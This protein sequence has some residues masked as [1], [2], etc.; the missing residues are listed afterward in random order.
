[1]WQ[2]QD[3]STRLCVQGKGQQS[4]ALHLVLSLRKTSPGNII[5]GDSILCSNSKTST[6]VPARRCKPARTRKKKGWGDV[7]VWEGDKS[8]SCFNPRWF[9]FKKKNNNQFLFSFSCLFS[10]ERVIFSLP[11]FLL[12]R[13]TFFF[14]LALQEEEEKKVCRRK[15]RR[16][17]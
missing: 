15:W 17:G 7:C 13:P 16:N 12:H 6:Y 11:V 14:F 2:E 4:T 3:G 10:L 8:F 5:S 9:H 1:M